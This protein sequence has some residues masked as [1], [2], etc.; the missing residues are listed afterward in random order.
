[1]LIHVIRRCTQYFTNWID[2]LGVA[3]VYA[4]GGGRGA[5]K[6]KDHTVRKKNVYDELRAS[7]REATSYFYR[8]TLVLTP[9]RW[10]ER[11]FGNCL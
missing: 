10:L 6:K 4:P 2:G 3:Q 5:K 8:T 1:M 11:T 7:T 9:S